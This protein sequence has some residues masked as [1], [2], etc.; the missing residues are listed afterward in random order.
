MGYEIVSSKFVEGDTCYRCGASKK[1]SRDGVKCSAWG[2]SYKRHMFASK[3]IK[4][5]KVPR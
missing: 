4:A 1:E 5:V 2:R 3:N